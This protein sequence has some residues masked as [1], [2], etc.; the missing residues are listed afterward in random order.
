M[1]VFTALLTFNIC[2]CCKLVE[3]HSDVLQ[4]YSSKT[5]WKKRRYHF[6]VKFV[7]ACLFMLQLLSN[8]ASKWY[9]LA[10]KSRLF[11]WERRCTEQLH[12]V[13]AEKVWCW[14]SSLRC[15]WWSTPLTG[16]DSGRHCHCSSSSDEDDQHR[17]CRRRRHLI[18]EMKKLCSSITS[19]P[20]AGST[21]EGTC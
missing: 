11:E 16:T 18:G 13:L 17:S 14:S 3:H 6:Q 15:K 10:C 1:F 4:Y 8:W 19:R 9:A 7:C 20:G 21:S 2:S 12:R 5:L